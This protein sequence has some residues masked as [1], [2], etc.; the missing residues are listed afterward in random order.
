MTSEVEVRFRA[1][2]LERTRVELEHRNLERHGGGWEQMRDAVGSPGG[3]ARGL[4]ALG[5]HVM[6]DR[7]GI[8]SNP[9]MSAMVSRCEL[10]EVAATA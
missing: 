8:G 4:E 3:W 1:E 10:I 7:F 2:G 5:H 9:A 6:A